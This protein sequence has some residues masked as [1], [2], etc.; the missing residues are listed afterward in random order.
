MIWESIKE[1]STNYLPGRLLSRRAFKTD[2][3]FLEKISAGATGTTRVF[4][5]LKRQ[6]HSPIELER[7]SMSFKIW[8]KIKIKRVRV[9]DILCVR[10]GIR[11]ESRAKT[12]LQITMSHSISDPLRGWD[13]GL[14][15]G[16]FIAF[17]NCVK[18]GERPIDWK[19]DELVQYVKVE[20]MRKA[21]AENKVVSI[22]PKGVTE[23]FEARLT[24]P[25]AVAKADGHVTSIDLNCLK[26]RR[27]DDN[28][29][30][31]LSLKKGELVLTPLVK[32]DD[33]IKRN[34]I[35]ASVVAASDK[36]RCGG[37]LI[38]SYYIELM[39][40]ASLSDRY[41]AA[42]AL[43]FF[44]SNETISTLKD[45]MRDEKEHIYIRLESA[46]SL[47]KMGN[48][49]SLTF[50]EK[51]LYDQY[52]ENRLECVIVLGEIGQRESS[53]LLIKTLLDTKQH[54][55]IRA[56]AA[57][58]L[59]EL[60]DKS[61]LNALVTAFDAVDK[62]I[63]VEAARAMVK[64]NELFAQET[65]KLIPAS[66]DSQRAGI[67]W[68]LSKSGNFTIHDLLAVINN[69]DARKWIAWIIGT[70][71]EQKYISQIEELIQKDK[72]VYFA[73]TVL[74][75]VMSSWINGLEIY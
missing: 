37:N 31:R 42:K 75:K 56:G 64:L 8:K 25:S 10:C 43:S 12:D 57:W 26:Y 70:Q 71:K 11:V 74:W 41:G 20:E 50:F 30:I 69:D 73:V 47:L 27:K 63:R 14:T 5:D 32:V 48:K 66:N 59:G 13:F 7:G 4:A 46:S 34:R 3:S 18:S 6:G 38:Q 54:P 58:S 9:P 52:L 17:V 36:I 72:E 35:L 33:T 40:S 53:D 28:R 22:K 29:M 51:L 45:K 1:Q 16:D 68:S 67:S 15:D 65:V 62:D 2:A 60:K 61:A 44:K 39:K 19:A 55:E 23:G 49:E 21:L 24:W